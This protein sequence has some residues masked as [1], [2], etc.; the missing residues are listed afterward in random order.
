MEN[1]STTT[2]STTTISPDDIKR[3]ETDKNFR[4]AIVAAKIR[5][6]RQMEVGFCE[7]SAK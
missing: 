7:L 4:L 2:K 3:A 1:K 6:Q 5:H